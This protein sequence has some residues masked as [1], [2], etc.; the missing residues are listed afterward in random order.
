V[1]PG[2]YILYCMVEIRITIRLWRWRSRAAV[3]KFI[4]SARDLARQD[5][6][7]RGVLVETSSFSFSIFFCLATADFLTT[8]IEPSSISAFQPPVRLRIESNGL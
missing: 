4:L 5:S 1:N 3:E 2:V 6:N 7:G 8:Q